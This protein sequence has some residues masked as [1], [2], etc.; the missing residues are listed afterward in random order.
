MKIKKK[1]N[2]L[3]SFS[4]Q[5]DNQSK[6]L[7]F[8]AK[9]SIHLQLMYFYKMVEFSDL[10]PVA[11]LVLKTSLE[12]KQVYIHRFNMS[13]HGNSYH[14]TAKPYLSQFFYSHQNG[15]KLQLSAEIICHCPNCIK[16]QRK[17]EQHPLA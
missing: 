2:C 14:Y 3:L 17:T 12:I 5:E 1:Y 4:N 8:I 16:P 9:R 11:P 13:S 15:Y 7:K 6:T 10:H